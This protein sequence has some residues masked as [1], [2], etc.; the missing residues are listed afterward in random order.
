V[1]PQFAEFEMAAGVVP[2]SPGLE[3]RAGRR[4]RMSVISEGRR[5][6]TNP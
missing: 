1:Y 6:R 5:T 3:A 2:N 4:E